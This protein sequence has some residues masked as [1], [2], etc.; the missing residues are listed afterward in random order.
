MIINT[1]R[2]NKRFQ[3]HFSRN[4]PWNLENDEVG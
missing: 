2:K 4:G 3:L 1:H